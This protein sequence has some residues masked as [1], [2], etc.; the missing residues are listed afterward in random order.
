MNKRILNFLIFLILF[1]SIFFSILLGYSIKYFQ[2]GGQRYLYLKKIVYFIADI[3]KPFIAMVKSKSLNPNNLP[4]LTKHKNKKNFQR[5]LQSEKNALLILPR[6]DHSINRSIVEVI[7]LQTF[8]V[9]H[10]YMHNIKNMNDKIKK[11]KL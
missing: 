6:Y 1:L 4:S 11:R 7:D 2:E 3:P 8:K 5:F 9:I 10:K